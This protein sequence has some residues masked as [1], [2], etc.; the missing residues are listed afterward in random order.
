MFTI[1]KACGDAKVRKVVFTTYED[2]GRLTAK[3]LCSQITAYGRGMKPQFEGMKEAKAYAKS[4]K[5]SVVHMITSYLDQVKL[6]KQ[7]NTLEYIFDFFSKFSK[8]LFNQETSKRSLCMIADS[9]GDLFV[10]SEFEQSFESS[11]CEYNR[12]YADG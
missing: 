1:F 10:T 9:K 5:I 11:V 12:N 2:V 8:Y 3:G 6:Y 4:L 7:S